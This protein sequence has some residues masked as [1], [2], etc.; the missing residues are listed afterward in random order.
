MVDSTRLAG[1]RAFVTGAGSGIGRSVAIRAASEGAVVGAADL[2]AELA[3]QTVE[4]ITAA[5]GRALTLPVDIGNE[6]QVADAVERAADEFGGL[7]AV[8]ANAGTSASGWI[9]ET[10]LADW[11]AVLRVNLTGVFLTAKHTIPH[12][13]EA[14]GGSVVTVGSVA[15]HIVGPAGSAASYAASKGGVLQ[16]TKQIAVDYGEQ[17]IR[18][19][20]VCPGGVKTGLARHVGEDLR[21]HSTPIPEGG[22]LPRSVARP[23]IPRMS[24]PNEQAAVIAFLLSE[25]ASFM[26]GTSVMVDGGFTAI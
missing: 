22:H 8:V 3:E 13:I 11:E 4:E 20:C 6:A 10:E 5:G 21:S 26:T 18:A 1:R 7:D 24:H 14:G 15:S 9:H 16:L 17:R 19:N 12:L 23:P 2:R 25:E